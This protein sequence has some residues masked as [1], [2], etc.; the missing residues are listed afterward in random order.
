MTVRS[1]GR[2]PAASISKSTRSSIVKAVFSAVVVAL[3]FVVTYGAAPHAFALHDVLGI[4]SLA[5]VVNAVL[6]LP[7]LLF[8]HFRHQLVVNAVI[9]GTVLAGALTM[10]V[11][12]TSLYREGAAILV[13]LSG[14]AYLT[15]LVVLKAIDDRPGAGAVLTTVALLGVGIVGIP[16]LAP[17]HHAGAASAPTAPNIWFSEKP[18]VYLVGFDGVTPAALLSK[19]GANSTPFHDVM[20]DR[21]RT[22]RNFFSNKQHTLG[23]YNMVLSLDDPYLMEL[24]VNEDVRLFSGTH[25]APLFRMFR[26]NGYEITTLYMDRYFGE[27]RGP[28]IDNYIVTKNE[29]AC[30]KLDRT[31]L[32]ISFYGYCAI[33]PLLETVWPAVD[34][35]M[36]NRRVVERLLRRSELQRPQLV[37]AHIYSPGHTGLDFDME[38][39]MAVFAPRYLTNAD[40]AGVL[41]AR[42]IDHLEVHDPNAILFVFGDH[43]PWLTRSL[44]GK[45]NWSLAITDRQGTVGGV[46]PPQRCSAH[47]DPPAGRTTNYMTTMD[48]VYGIIRC[49]M[50]ESGTADENSAASLERTEW[51]AFGDGGHLAYGDF[52]YE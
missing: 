37:V 19:F 17:H 3:A 44:N 6:L 22:F 5:L 43:G 45:E 14:V 31:L 50:G 46:F 42:I 23:L 32:E 41:L 24:D 34:S 13:A 52:L 28:Y 26:R 10:Y 30:R 33:R 18:N 12:H 40:F 25:D 2:L 8:R 39:D 15:L 47:L 21:F 4:L 27:R 7:T 29:T 49:L 16:V 11:V 9:A 20:S 51:Y 48:V 35:S 1:Q 36:A 38:D